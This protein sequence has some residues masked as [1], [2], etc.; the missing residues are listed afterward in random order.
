ML[1]ARSNRGGDGDSTQRSNAT[2]ATADSFAIV[3]PKIAGVVFD[4]PAG[5]VPP[6][7]TV[8]VSVSCQVTFFLVMNI[9]F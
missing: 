9:F 4:P 7:G 5:T 3:G 8:T 1:S 6:L 2:D